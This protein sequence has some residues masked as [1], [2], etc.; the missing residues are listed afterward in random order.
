M[1]NGN[2]MAVCTD[3]STI[4][5]EIRN[6]DY[7]IIAAITSSEV[8][9]IPTIHYAGILMPPTQMLYAWAEGNTTILQTEYPK[10]LL[11]QD[12]DDMIVALIA[13]MTKKNVILYIPE[14]E[15]RVYGLMLLNHLYYVYGITVGSPI[16]RTQFNFDMN[17]IPFVISKFYMM[18]IM[19]AQDYIQAYP[20]N[21]A[22]P[23]FVINKLAQDLHPFNRQA[24]W[25]EYVQYFNE[26]NAAKAFNQP[27]Q[28]MIRM[29]K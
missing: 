5:N 2:I 25:Q 12:C 13:A 23:E 1:F 27:K 21:Y 26:L 24:S 18:G 8:P 15:F 28:Q 9:A 11:T 17:K 29:V 14:D 10:Y 4:P 16:Y 3:L 20:A 6:I 22:L 19:D 7:Y